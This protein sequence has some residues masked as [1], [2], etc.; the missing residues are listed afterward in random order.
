MHLNLGCGD[1]Y[2]DGWHNV[3][4]A[5]SPHRKDETVDLTGPLP[6]L[7]G[8]VQLAYAG[9]LLEHLTLD[10]CHLLLTNLRP[11]MAPDGE[12]MVVGPDATIAR[13]LAAAGTLDITLDSLL[14]GAQRWPGD[15]HLW[16]S[17]AAITVDLLTDA[18]W[19]GIHELAVV[20]VDQKWPIGDRRP[21]WQFAIGARP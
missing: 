21:V 13:A 11:C 12:L 18:G 16:E 5:G 9:H 14:Y 4:H 2:A 8:T 1:W 17:T 3:D 10:G 7:P 20:D 19:Q 15:Q 6:W